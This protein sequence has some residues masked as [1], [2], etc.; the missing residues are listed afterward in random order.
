[1]IKREDLKIGDVIK[2]NSKGK[3]SDNGEEV[4]IIKR[5]D[6]L[7]LDNIRYYCMIGETKRGKQ[8]ST[9]YIKVP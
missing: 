6:E 8:W 7:V 4:T 1:M 2:V 3:I 9:D 5:T